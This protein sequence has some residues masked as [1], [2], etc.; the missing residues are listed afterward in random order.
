MCG[1]SD[2]YRYDN[3]R[4]DG[5]WFC[6]VCGSGDGLS[7]LQN[8]MNLDF[9]AAAKMVDE[10][11]D[12]NDIDEKPFRERQN[13][14]ERRANL[15]RLWR[16]ATSEEVWRKYLASRGIKGDVLDRVEDV[17]GHH[18]LQLHDSDPEIAGKY[19]AMV[20]LIRDA[21]GDPASIH[22]T[23]L[24]TKIG[25]QKKIMPTVNSISGGYVR[26]MRP[27]EQLG[28][29]EGIETALSFTM[30]TG[31]PA[32][33]CI[34]AHNLEHFDSVPEHVRQ[35]FVVAD[36]DESFV[37]QAA[38]FACAKRMKVKRHKDMVMVW[39]PRPMGWDCNDWLM[40]G[41]AEIEGSML[42]WTG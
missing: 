29:A 25:K 3:N 15:N 10:L 32:W 35:V 33:A 26:L 12:D 21:N 39:M 22:R 36:N 6:N 4:N 20:S 9:A 17:R 37:G 30:A 14:E 11:L 41:G 34:S 40:N 7:L 1:G 23:Y 16:S 2:R 28:L 5:D 24:D 19:P 8:A 31:V 42:L 38:A 18:A 13:T 27:D